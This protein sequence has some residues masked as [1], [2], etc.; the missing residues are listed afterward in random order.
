VFD[1]VR[2]L[3]GAPIWFFVI[4][5]ALWRGQWPERTVA[6]INL[7]AML[8]TPL[9]Q[10][11]P[12]APHL[13]VNVLL[14]DLAVLVGFTIVALKSD[15]W[16]PLFATAAALMTVLTD[17]AY[18]WVHLAQRL[19]MTGEIVWSYISLFALAG[20]LAEV[21]WRRRHLRHASLA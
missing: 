1:I 15:R 2:Y 18:G 3:I 12:L 17:A 5:L 8:L 11:R 21:E 9:V 7:V 6:T 10:T 14:V 16:W 4:G 19:A 20:G 13:Q